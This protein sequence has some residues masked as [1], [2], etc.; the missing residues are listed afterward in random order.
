VDWEEG[1]HFNFYLSEKRNENK[2]FIYA[3]EK[4]GRKEGTQKLL[5]K[6]ISS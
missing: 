5:V 6:K 2:T 3:Q 4:K 1:L